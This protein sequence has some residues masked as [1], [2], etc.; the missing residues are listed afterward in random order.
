M[1]TLTLMSLL[2]LASCSSHTYRKVNGKTEHTVFCASYRADRMTYG[3]DKEAKE[4]CYGEK[5]NVLSEK[6]E[7]GSFRTYDEEKIT[8]R[9]E[10]VFTCN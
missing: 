5:Y 1:K 3:C 10:R 4:L 8:Y 9:T 2:L 6:I 7:I